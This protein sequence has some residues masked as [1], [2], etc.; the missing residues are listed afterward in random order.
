MNEFGIM[1]SIEQKTGSENYPAN[2][3][4]RIVAEFDKKMEGQKGYAGV[5][6]FGSSLE[7]YSGESSD[8]DIFFFYDSSL[9]KK[10]KEKSILKAFNQKNPYGDLYTSVGTAKKEVSDTHQKKLEI[11]NWED[12]NPEKMIANLNSEEFYELA[13]SAARINTVRKLTALCGL[14]VGASMHDYREYFKRYFQTLSEDRRGIIAS[15]VL[16][17][18]LKRDA[19][20][21]PK[22][23][24]RN[25]ELDD[26]FRED[27]LNTR[28]QYWQ[29][30]IEDIY[31]IQTEA[32][33][34]KIKAEYISKK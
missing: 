33:D 29:K 10:E 19:A 2:E 13:D 9:Y 17:S 3:I 15:A 11:H 7:D 18:L 24:N 28:K 23:M 14:S 26:A 12:I 16:R 30:S 20:S 34:D 21:I 25:A 5:T 1:P 27:F 6:V 4:P 31:G 22:R 8:V 32:E